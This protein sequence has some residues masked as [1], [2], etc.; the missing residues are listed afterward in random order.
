MDDKNQKER[1]EQELKFLRES[2]D[3]EV[4]SKEEFEK[5]KN[6]IEEKLKAIGKLE[7]KPIQEKAEENDEAIEEKTDEKIRLKVVQDEDE[8]FHENPKQEQGETS[9]SIPAESKKGGEEK[10][11]KFFKYA[12]VFIVLLLAAFFAYSFVN[13]ET[14]KRQNNIIPPEPQ[15]INVIVLN[16]RNSCFNCDTTRILGILEG[17]FGPLNAKE[18]DFSTE[19]G[20]RMAQKFDAAALPMYFLDENITKSASYAQLKRIFLKKN[21]SYVLSEDVAAPN[22]YFKREDIPNRLDFFAKPDDSASIKA[23][24][25]LQGFLNAF[26]ASFG[27]HAPNDEITKELGIRNF[28]AFLVNNRVKFS[29]VHTAETI[30]SNFCRL[31]KVPECSVS[32]SKNLI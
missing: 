23:E 26:K 22:F 16:D 24:R 21:E 5:G 1:L 6:R 25:N 11:G 27:K 17:W 19:E 2:F 18:V 32:L 4:I 12:V 8:H 15:K 29:G 13:K 28:P 3:A 30:K 20:K 10:E 9:Y 7:D 14:G 31:N